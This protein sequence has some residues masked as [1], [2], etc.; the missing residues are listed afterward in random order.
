[1]QV[2]ATFVLRMN[3]LAG[4]AVTD[5]HRLLAADTGLLLIFVFLLLPQIVK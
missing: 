4:T 5:R 1:M 2:T 3:A